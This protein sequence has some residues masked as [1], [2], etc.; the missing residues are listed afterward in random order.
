LSITKEEE[1]EVIV[2]V[3]VVLGTMM[4]TLQNTVPNYPSI[5]RIKNADACE[6]HVT[7]DLVLVPIHSENIFTSKNRHISMKLCSCHM[8]T[9]TTQW[10]NKIK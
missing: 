1:K 9:R 4:V 5:M 10:H 6:A 8:H 3:M 2:V 7:P